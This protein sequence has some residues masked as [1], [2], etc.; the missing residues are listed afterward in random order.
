M[1]QLAPVRSEI[2]GASALSKLHMYVHVYR[3][4]VYWKD[5]VL[6]DMYAVQ[7]QLCVWRSNGQ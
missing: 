4:L 1:S 5:T 7:V 6:Y 3:A 2:N